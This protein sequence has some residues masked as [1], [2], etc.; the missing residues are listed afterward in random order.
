MILLTRD[1]TCQQA[2]E[3][4]TD[5]L[6]NTLSRR[7]RRRLEKH[8]RDCINCATYLDQIRA[9]IRL[10]GSVQ[11]DQLDAATREGLIDLYRKYRAEESE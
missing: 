8:L 2:V 5:Y 9:A 3:L 4:V 6:E 1:L 10:A 7:Q 11:P